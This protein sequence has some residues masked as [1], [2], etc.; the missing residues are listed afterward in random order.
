MLNTLSKTAQGKFSFAPRPRVVI[1]V[2]MVLPRL[3][4]AVE[5]AA[6]MLGRGGL[7]DEEP[8][9]AAIGSRII[10]MLKEYD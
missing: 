9:A 3:R 8:L 1:G 4:R 2:P 5:E 10:P 6:M 7:S